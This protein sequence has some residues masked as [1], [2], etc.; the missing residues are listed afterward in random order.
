M[1][2]PTSPGS[3]HPLAWLD[4]VSHD[5][6]TTTT[7]LEQLFGWSETNRLDID[8]NDYLFFADSGRPMHG[9]EQIRPDQGSAR[10]TVFVVTPDARSLV[11]R[12]EASGGKV[13]L[14]P[15]PLAHL[16][17]IAMVTDPLGATLGI[18]QPLALV[19]ASIASSAAPFVAARLHTKDLQRTSTFLCE[20]FGW[21]PLDDSTVDEEFSGTSHPRLPT[22]GPLRLH[23]GGAIAELVPSHQG[24]WVPVFSDTRAGVSELATSLGGTAA[25]VD[26]DLIR[27]ADPAGAEFLLHSRTT[28]QIDAVTP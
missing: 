18:W 2:H 27:V 17:I 19:P 22:R 3:R 5:I 11:A 9:A 13:S 25:P 10:W 1:T 23:T 6:A 12:A 4:V 14:A 24:E 7:F 15:T 26:D 16:G 8:G 20:V 28:V 21:A